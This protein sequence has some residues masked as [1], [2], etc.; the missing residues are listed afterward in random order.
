[1]KNLFI[2]YITL[3]RLNKPIGIFL[4]AWPS[5]IALLIAS[6][7]SPPFNILIIFIS[8]IIIMRSAGC[9]IND[10][11]DKDIDKFVRRTYK[12]PLANGALNPNHALILFFSLL[13]ISLYLVLHLNWLS[14]K[15]SVIGVILTSIYPF[16]KRFIHFP[17]LFLGLA[18]AWGIPMA[19]AAVNN[20]LSMNTLLLFLACIPWIVAYDT[21]YALC[22]KTDDLKIGVKSTAILFCQHV[23]LCIGLL[24]ILSLVIFVCIGLYNSFKLWYFMGLFGALL[25][26]LYQLHLIKDGQTNNY[27][28]AFLNNHYFGALI[29]IGLCL[30]YWMK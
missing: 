29:F 27:F 5:L 9:V 3:M 30:D 19:F 12:R 24:Q 14:I 1:M 10:W 20:H 13:I 15:L 6:K 7:G 2:N 11:A 8:G 23:I 4:L 17:Q 18:F 21:E 25:M 22:D 28:K 16:L 26:V